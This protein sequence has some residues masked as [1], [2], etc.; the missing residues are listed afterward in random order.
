M[1][2]QNIINLLDNTTNQ[3]SKF[4]PRNW[5]KIN[6]ESTGKY[7]NSNIRFKMSLIR[8]NL[9]G[10]SNAFILVK[11]NI[12]V[13]NVAAACAIVNNTNKKIIFKNCAPF[14]DCITKINNTQ[15]DDAQ[16]I[17]ILM[18]MYNLIEYSDAYLR[19][20]TSLLQYY[21]DE[22]ALDNSNNIIEFPAGNNNSIS[23]KFKQKI[24]GQTGNRGTSDV[25]IMIPFKYLSNFWRTLE[26]LANQKPE[27]Q[28]TITKLYAPVVILLTQDNIT[29]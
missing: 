11:G 26:M 9:C 18:P 21:R 25:E 8:S 13:P 1:K 28:I 10:Y 22:P 12:T 24:T 16:K 7:D 17:D 3:A 19:K 4:R 15:V 6:D 20:W 29:P 14:T 2:Y 5:V 27:F 23:F